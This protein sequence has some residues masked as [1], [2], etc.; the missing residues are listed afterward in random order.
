MTLISDLKLHNDGDRWGFAMGAWF[1]I[2]DE[3]AYREYWQHVDAA[4][5]PVEWDYVPSLTTQRGERLPENE[6]YGLE[7]YA[8]DELLHAGH[9]LARYTDR[10][11]AHGL[12]Y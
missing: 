3:L 11:R 6:C 4:E 5:I 12:D 1:A 8:S 10:L 9:V 2:C 7:H